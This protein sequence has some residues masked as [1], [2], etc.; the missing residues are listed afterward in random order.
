MSSDLPSFGMPPVAEVAMSIQFRPIEQLHA[1]HVGLFWQKIRSCFPNLDEQPPLSHDSISPDFL[2]QNRVRFH[3]SNQPDVPRTWFVEDD[4]GR[5][6]QLQRDRFIFNWRRLS[7]ADEYPRYPSVQRA[8]FGYW[9]EFCS[10]LSENSLGEPEVDLLELTYVNLIPEGDAW[11]EVV[12]LQELLL[13]FAWRTRSGFLPAPEGVKAVL[14]FRLPHKA[15]QLQVEVYPVA[16]EGKP[17]T[18]RLALT[19]KGL[20]HRL[21]AADAIVE[22][23]GLARRWIV[24]GFA[25]LVTTR[26]DQLWEKKS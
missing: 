2:A 18:F 24:C 21:D 8:F 4:G 19:A 14:L 9:N 25:D 23:F 3:F 6:I 5:L 12:D 20:P 1:A 13:P 10:F 16:L 15:G 22:W 11:S 7:E 26:T 17:R